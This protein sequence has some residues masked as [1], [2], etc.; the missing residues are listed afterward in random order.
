MLGDNSGRQASPGELALNP[1]KLV[2]M[3]DIRQDRLDERHAVLKQ[4]L[5]ERVDVPA[6]R[7]FLEADLE[8][9][10]QVLRRPVRATAPAE[11][12]IEEVGRIIGYDKV[13]ATELPHNPRGDASRIVQE[14]FYNPKIQLYLSIPR[15]R[16]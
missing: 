16:S 8:V 3:A 1:V 10:A 2:A 14:N 5:G 13:P 7:R 4:A 9:V 6:E 15:R 12:L 11:D